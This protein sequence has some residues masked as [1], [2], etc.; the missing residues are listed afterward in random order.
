MT[1]F[2]VCEEH[3]PYVEWCDP[4]VERAIAALTD[5]QARAF[6]VAVK[7]EIEVGRSVR[8]FVGETRIN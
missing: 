5:E 6:V 7:P 3:G 1:E 4:C 2:P 8:P